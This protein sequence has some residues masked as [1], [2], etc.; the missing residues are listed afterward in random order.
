M[1]L[2][3][4]I[5]LA[6]LT[7][8]AAACPRDEGTALTPPSPEQAPEPRDG[9]VLSGDAFKTALQ[10]ARAA[11]REVMDGKRDGITPRQHDVLLLKALRDAMAG[12]ELTAPLYGDPGRG[13]DMTLRMVETYY[14]PGGSGERLTLAET[15]RRLDEDDTSPPVIDAMVAYMLRDVLRTTACYSY[16]RDP[17]TDDVQILAVHPDCSPGTASK[18][19]CC[20]IQCK[21]SAVSGFRKCSNCCDS[22]TQL[23][24]NDPEDPGIV[25]V[26]C[27][28]EGGGRRSCPPR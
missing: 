5:A 24:I 28:D 19:D 10:E 21:D 13:I 25:Y 22:W 1:R 17:Q 11:L 15:R 26:F 12:S 16:R 9:D 27:F 8:L 23:E 18:P 14:R 20:W 3:A 4:T 6:G 7:V 2:S